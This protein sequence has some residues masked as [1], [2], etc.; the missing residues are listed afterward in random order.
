MYTTISVNKSRLTFQE[1]IAYHINTYVAILLKTFSFRQQKP[2]K[3]ISSMRVKFLFSG[4]NQRELSSSDLLTSF[5]DSANKFIIIIS[6]GKLW[7]I[8]VLVK[9][10]VGQIAKHTSW[11]AKHKKATHRQV[12]ALSS[13]SLKNVETEIEHSFFRSVRVWKRHWHFLKVATTHLIFRVWCGA[14]VFSLSRK[15]NNIFYRSIGNTI[16][17]FW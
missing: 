2:L 15:Y 12:K 4:E 17:Q 9:Y 5:R 3:L 11:G 16:C 10:F 8:R 14:Y 1:H 7:I 13:E 6:T